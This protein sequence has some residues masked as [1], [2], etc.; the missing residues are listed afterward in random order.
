MKNG[1]IK[2]AKNFRCPP[3]LHTC[4]FGVLYLAS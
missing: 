1:S 3:L 4:I 2:F